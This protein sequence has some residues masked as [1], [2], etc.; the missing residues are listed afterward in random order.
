ME[1][2][3]IKS[4][5]FLSIVLLGYILKTKGFFKKEDSQLISK[6]V[7]RIT[8]PCAV[9]SSAVQLTFTQVTIIV[10]VVAIVTDLIMGLVGKF[11]F[12]KNG[13]IERASAIIN[14]SGYNVANVTIPFVQAF[15]PGIGMGY[16]CMFDI[17]NSIGWLGLTV[18]WGKAEADENARFSVKHLINTLLHSIPFLTYI[19]IFTLGVLKLSLPIPIASVVTT[20][21]SANSFLVMLMIGMMIDFKMTKEQFVSVFKIV[22]LRLAGFI[23]FSILIVFLLPVPMLAKTI[24]LLCIVPSAP[25]ISIVFS[26]ELGDESAIPAFINSISLIL[27]IVCSTIILLFSV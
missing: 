6:I 18:S 22:G 1:A 20:I 23:V 10:M 11:A 19:L 24:L 9:L 14:T 13:N 3:L 8:L 16:V 12:A 26:K 25:S 5:T 2:V 17:G 4:F 21:G 27:G 7:S 15:F